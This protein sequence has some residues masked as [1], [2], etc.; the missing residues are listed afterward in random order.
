MTSEW[1]PFAAA[2]GLGALVLE[3][4]QLALYIQRT[5]HTP[6]ISRDRRRRTDRYGQPLPRLPIF[7]LAVAC[8][9]VAGVVL[10]GALAIGGQVAS[11]LTA[12][13][14]GAGA[15]N[16]LQRSTEQV[17]LPKDTGAPGATP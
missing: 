12:L 7:F 11:P 9:V 4:A 14:L 10:V 13:L 6:W 3:C 5:G 17:A 8:K 1:L 16:L 2:G 15:T